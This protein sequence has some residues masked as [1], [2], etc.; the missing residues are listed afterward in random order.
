MKNTFTWQWCLQRQG[1][2]Q[3][4]H[5]RLQSFLPLVKDN[6]LNYSI[7]DI[8]TISPTYLL[9][10]NTTNSKNTACSPR[11]RDCAQAISWHKRIATAACVGTRHTV[12]I[13][14][15]NIRA[16]LSI[17]VRCLLIDF[18]LYWYPVPLFDKT[19]KKNSRE[20][21]SHIQSFSW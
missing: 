10:T 2:L 16:S 5:R 7:Q 18:P 11:T 6:I 9:K 21:G 19:K 17:H 15:L 14:I 8:K 3:K 1:I 20:H 4:R 12:N 13:V